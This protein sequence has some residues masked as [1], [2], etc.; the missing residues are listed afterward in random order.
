MRDTKASCKLLDELDDTWLYSIQHLQALEKQLK[1]AI[2]F[3]EDM[4]T[5]VDSLKTLRKRLNGL[6]AFNKFM[7]DNNSTLNTI[8]TKNYCLFDDPYDVTDLELNIM[9]YVQACEAA[10]DEKSWIGC[11]INDILDTF[12]NVNQ[13]KV[14]Y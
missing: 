13:Q 8:A 2:A 14:R 10:Y 12:S 4:Q 5:N 9:E 6:I 7:N 3:V 11:H 1:D